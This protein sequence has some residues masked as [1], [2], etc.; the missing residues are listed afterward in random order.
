MFHN[1]LAH[2]LTRELD[3]NDPKTTLF[4]RQILEK[5]QF[6]N[7][8][9]QEWYDLIMASLPELPG[10]VLE[11]GS[12]AGFLNKYIPD[13]ITSDIF[14]G[15]EISVLLDAQRLPIQEKGLKAIVMTDVLHHLPQPDLFF[16]EASRCVKSGGVI[17]MIEPW[18]T[19]WSKFVYRKLHYEPLDIYTQNWGFSTTGPL[20]GANAAIP[21]IIFDRDYNI[22]THEFPQWVVQPIKII[23]PFRYLL[24]GGISMKNLMPG[25]SFPF[26]KYFES[27]LSPWMNSLGMFAKIVLVKR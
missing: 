1:L 22:F 20:S 2:P 27:T 17:I 4:R 3:L 11:I 24:S 26:W 9:Y 12:G 21:W 15:L 14:R 19:R 13:L 18:A 5:K 23:M 7:R 16:R 8:I 6:L 25:W 10:K